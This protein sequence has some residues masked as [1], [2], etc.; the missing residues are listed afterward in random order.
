MMIW[1]VILDIQ[2]YFKIPVQE[3]SNPG[4]SCFP[5][6]AD[7]A[8]RAPTGSQESSSIGKTTDILVFIDS[9]SMWSIFYM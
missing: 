2:K 5:G 6:K 7:P 3:C 4:K 9:I 8:N 1:K